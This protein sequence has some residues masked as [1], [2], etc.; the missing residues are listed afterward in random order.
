MPVTVISK[1]YKIDLYAIRIWNFRLRNLINSKSASFY[2]FCEKL[3]SLPSDQ[4]SDM[5][6]LRNEFF[7]NVR[8]PFYDEVVFKDNSYLWSTEKLKIKIKELKLAFTTFCKLNRIHESIPTSWKL[9]IF[10][11]KMLLIRFVT[12]KPSKFMTIHFH[13]SVNGY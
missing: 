8:G 2:A 7:E 4:N 5:P 9:I 3:S 10:L 12:N 13:I 1:F 11:Q 6:F